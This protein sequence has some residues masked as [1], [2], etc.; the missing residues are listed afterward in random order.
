MHC[1]QCGKE[2]HE[3][4]KFCRYCG[5]K[6][7]TAN[8]SKL[9]FHLSTKK[10]LCIIVPLAIIALIWIVYPSVADYFYA[11]D[12]YAQAQKL[13]TS[14]QYQSALDKLNSTQGKWTILST[15]N[16]INA[17]KQ[18]EQKNIGW[19][20]DYDNALANVAS[21]SYDTAQTLLQGIDTSY[22]Q[23]NLVKNE[24]IVVQK[25]I[26]DDLTAKVSLA[27][28]NAAA[29][30]AAAV[31]AQNAAATASANAATQAEQARTAEVR[32]SFT[33]Q[34]L[35]IYSNLIDNGKSYYAQGIQDYNTNNNAPALV[36][37]AKAN[38]VF[39][40]VRT[41]AT[42]LNTTFTGMP[43]TY[44]DAANNLESAANN[45]ILATNSVI[46]SNSSAYVNNDTTTN[47]Y[48]NLAVSYT[49]L[50]YNFLKSAGY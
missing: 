28:K 2:N 24:L 22:P 26:Q 13:E 41:D 35:S 30:K 43:Q 50:V 1:H 17:L 34:L 39:D 6:L 23:Y 16:D 49:S 47:Y 14:G 12:A 8:S 9:N 42:N 48:K 7:A 31:A 29:Q 45:Y 33:N 40:S 44:V 20:N 25:D 38:A 10:I 18:R 19:Q 4:S 36:L 27:Q 3:N 32:K 21:S 15:Q 37:F 46:D 11:Q 5:T